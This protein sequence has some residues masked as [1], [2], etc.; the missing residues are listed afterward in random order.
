MFPLQD[1]ID[2]ENDDLSDAGSNWS[3]EV[4]WTNPLDHIDL[5]TRFTATMTG[6]F[7]MPCIAMIQL[8]THH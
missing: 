2:H 3:E 1:A 5:Y 6:K 8:A 7:I 4:L